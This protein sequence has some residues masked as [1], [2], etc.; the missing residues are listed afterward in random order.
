MTK[1]RSIQTNFTAGELDL[2][3]LGRSDLTAFDNGARELTNVQVAPTGGVSRRAGLAHVA[4]LPGAGRLIPMD[5][6][7]DGRALLAVT[8]GRL[9]VYRGGER[10]AELA[11]P[12][13]G[14]HLPAVRWA[15]SADV[16]L[17]T[18]PE[19]PPKRLIR[20]GTDGWR[21]ADWRFYQTDSGALRVPLY[22][23][24]SA[25][26]T[27]Q[28]DGTSG[29]VTLTASEPVFQGRDHVG[30]TIEI[31][32]KQ[33]EITIVDSAT[34]VQAETRE[35]LVD[36]QATID[37]REAAISPAR[38]WPIAVAFHQNRL[39]IGGTRD[40]P[41]RL[42]LSRTGDLFNFHLGEGKADNAIAVDLLADQVEAIT[43]LKPG[44][45][46]QIFTARAEWSLRGEPLTPAQARLERHTR[47]GSPIARY[48][49]PADVEGETV[50]VPR[51]GGQI[52]AFRPDEL[53]QRYAS[54]DLA[55]LAPHLVPEP[56]DAA[57][58]PQ[59]RIYYVLDASGTLAAATL[60]RGERVTA[61]SRL[62]TAHRIAAVAAQDGEVHVLVARPQGWHLERFA[63]GYQ[64]DAAL[65]GTSDRPQAHWS[66]L[67]HLDGAAVRVRA[68]GADAGTYTVEGG[69]IDL[70]E[71]AETIE[72]GLAYRHV[73]APLPPAGNPRTGPLGPGAATRL[74][75]CSFQLQA[76]AVLTVDT[77]TGLTPVPLHH[78]P[79]A[80]GPDG[81]PRF[82]GIVHRR[83]RGWQP[84]GDT[85]L[86]RISQDAPLP[87]TVLAVTSEIVVSL[88]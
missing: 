9:L 49:P 11:A 48:V 53:D 25:G 50:F 69:A 80:A 40:R 59:A 60:L 77:G 82:T 74:V 24:A 56:I 76:T 84:G 43:A 55:L 3:A 22:K 73:V 70:A 33:A 19:L 27:L 18:H 87:A 54:V 47:H 5:L 17:L 58:D 34:Q 8:D 85:P 46:L 16:M 52:R 23:F 45:Y 75:R 26:T 38:G 36:T 44:R 81:P 13:R 2:A 61:W 20:D 37:W 66:G 12:W 1:L 41:Q 6:G 31:K 35:D 68:D 39:V 67:A 30:V 7:G 28:P 10:V 88:Q 83:G 14:E 29:T 32:G 71:P 51:Q 4:S 62:T 79:W 72:A 42:W 86:W 78:L 63:D 65:Q 21:L 64:T 15:Q 57:Y